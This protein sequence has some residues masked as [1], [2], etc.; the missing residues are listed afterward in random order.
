MKAL[1]LAVALT[2][3]SASCGVALDGYYVARRPRMHTTIVETAPSGQ[4][5]TSL[6]F[7]GALG[8]DGQ[9]EVRCADRT[10]PVERAWSVDKTYRYRGG[11]TSMP[12]TTAVISEL[13]I[14]GLITTVVLGACTRDDIDDPIACSNLWIAA[15]FV[16][17]AVYSGIRAATAREP[18]LIDRRESDERL[19]LGAPT[20]EVAVACP[21][22]VTFAVGVMRGP[23]DDNR[24]AYGST[25]ARA[26]DD[27][28]SIDG[29]D[30]RGDVAALDLVGSPAALAGWAS[31]A[32][33]GLWARTSDGD[34]HRVEAD[35]CVV[36]RALT[37]MLTGEARQWF[38]PTVEGQATQLCP[39][40]APATP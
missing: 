17:D 31:I 19:Q 18:V 12:Y 4:A 25:E 5:Q 29:V 22:D 37:P 2:T 39:P 34:L 33:A 36:T 14:G 30:R 24:L 23:S 21:A 20:N 26:L 11:F 32:A 6:D 35:R 7:I 40:P 15:P 10:R 38:S 27:Q 9:L 8:A 16:A 13:L 28:R 3:T 1:V